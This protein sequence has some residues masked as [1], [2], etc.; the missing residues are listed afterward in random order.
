MKSNLIELGQNYIF[1]LA[2][3]DSIIRIISSVQP[4]YSFDPK[5]IRVLPSL[6]SEP[7]LIP[8]FNYR[9]Q[10]EQ[11][12]CESKQVYSPSNS[13]PKT[14]SWEVVTSKY[15]SRLLEL[16]RT[17]RDRFLSANYLSLRDIVNP[18]Y[19]KD[20]VLEIINSLYFSTDE[21]STLSQ[22]V[23]ILYA[24]KRSEER[25]I[26]SNLFRHEEK[27]AKLLSKEIF[28]IEI[29]P[30]V[31]G[32]FLQEILTQM[33]ERTIKHGLQ[34]CSP[35]VLK[36]IQSS[37]SK[38]KFQDILKAPSLEPNPG[39]S[40][41][42]LLE[43]TLFQRFSQNINYK[44]DEFIAYRFP[45]KESNDPIENIETI[46][47]SNFQLARSD[48]RIE[49]IAA[50]RSK[51]FFM[52]QDWVINIRFDTIINSRELNSHEFY[53]IGPGIILSIPFFPQ[54]R[55]IVGGG[56]GKDRTC[57]EFAFSNVGF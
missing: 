51:L 26:I 34:F 45:E 4:F 12:I 1:L 17:T 20:D 31:H 9:V 25:V 33:D 52:I 38:N 28:R 39:E 55:S 18:N 8:R 15:L 41:V 35:P 54:A 7:N 57:F 24:G 36:V 6:Y 5:E 11:T 14:N 56:I 44:K 42:D 46:D 49:F 3:P 40:L 37:V 19:N 53:N 43:S 23:K 16:K 29:L 10:V 2:N 48:S 13:P 47:S 22:L 30:L 32:I 50:T 27:F 21:K